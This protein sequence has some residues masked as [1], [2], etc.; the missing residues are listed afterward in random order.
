M[1]DADDM[2]SSIMHPAV[3]EEIEDVEHRVSSR[4]AG[5]SVERSCATQVVYSLGYTTTR[6]SCQAENDEYDSRR[7]RRN[8]FLINSQDVHAVSRRKA[9]GRRL[10]EFNGI[11]DANALHERDTDESQLHAFLCP[12]FLISGLNNPLL[13]PH[14]EHHYKMRWR[15]CCP[16]GHSC[17]YKLKTPYP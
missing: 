12:A 10:G 8:G 6:S 4:K 17:R 9:L 5:G 7:Q 2:N 3:A 16:R 11:I 1:I 14:C 13:V 15:R